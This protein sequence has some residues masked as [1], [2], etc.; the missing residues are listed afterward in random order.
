ML[1]SFLYIILGAMIFVAIEGPNETVL[2]TSSLKQIENFRAEFLSD[3][4]AFRNVSMV[5]D[6]YENYIKL[7]LDNF[8]H[9][10]YVA[11]DKNFVTLKD[12]QNKT[13]SK[14]WSFSASLFFSATAIT[15]I[16]TVLYSMVR[17]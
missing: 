8:T 15:A 16:G 1:L 2:K 12:I 17:H 13:Q 3:L 9:L 10:L 5:E 4:I 14:L 6:D 11:Y 7:K